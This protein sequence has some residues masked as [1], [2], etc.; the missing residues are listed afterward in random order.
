VL[1]RSALSAQQRL[2]DGEPPL[3]R[4]EGKP[5]RDYVYVSDVAAAFVAA[6]DGAR[7]GT[8]NVGTGVQTSTARVLEILQQTAGTALEPRQVE[9]QAGELQASA[10][11]SSA[12][13]RDLGWRP[14]VRIEDGLRQTFDWY[15][16]MKGA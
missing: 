15:R 8:Y 12:V 1:F 10:L 5:T 14:T 11:D 7:A 4:G 2:L 13:E 6:A 3:L 9:L 16:S